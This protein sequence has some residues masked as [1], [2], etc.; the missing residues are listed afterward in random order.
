MNQQESNY[1]LFTSNQELATP[2]DLFLNEELLRKS[3]LLLINRSNNL[4]YR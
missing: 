3:I 2:M 4:I 1:I